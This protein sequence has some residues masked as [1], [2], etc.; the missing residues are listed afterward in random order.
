MADGFLDKTSQL[1]KI[2]ETNPADD[3]LCYHTWIREIE[4][5]LTFQEAVH[6]DFGNDLSRGFIPDCT[7]EDIRRALTTSKIT[8]FSSKPIINGNFVTPSA[9]EAASYSGTGMIYTATVD[10]RDIA[11]ID[12]GQGQVATDNVIEYHTV[13]CRGM[14]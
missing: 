12:S 6:A 10:I 14:V 3:E 7:A 4:D 8:V 11:W 2:L 1:Q 9:M 5:I 13:S